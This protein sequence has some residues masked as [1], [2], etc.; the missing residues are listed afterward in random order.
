MQCT[1]QSMEKP[2]STKLFRYNFRLGAIFDK[3]VKIKNFQKSLLTLCVTNLQ[4]HAMY[5]TVY[6]EAY[7]H[8]I[9]LL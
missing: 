9:I 5:R 1:E 8:K 2:M 7:E 4:T 3:I 6:G